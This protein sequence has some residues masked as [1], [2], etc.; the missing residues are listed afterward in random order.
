MVLLTLKLCIH[1][2]FITTNTI[3][4]SN[5]NEQ[6]SPITGEEDQNMKMTVNGAYSIHLKPPQTMISDA[7]QQNSAY[8]SIF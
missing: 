4:L 1:Y 2:C 6:Q 3:S 8:E 7:D 5:N